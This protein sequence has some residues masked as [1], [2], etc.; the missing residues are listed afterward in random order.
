MKRLKT[1][2]QY[3]ESLSID[4][5]YNSIDLMESIKKNYECVKDFCQVFL[6]NNAIYYENEKEVELMIPSKNGVYGQ[7]ADNGFV[8]EHTHFSLL[9]MNDWGNKED[10]VCITSKTITFDKICENHPEQF[11][12]SALHRNATDSIL[13]QLVTLGVVEARQLEIRLSKQA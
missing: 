2:V 7:R 1:Y 11:L 6:Y 8:Y 9:P 10:M 4:L 5:R 12:V 3:R 13:A